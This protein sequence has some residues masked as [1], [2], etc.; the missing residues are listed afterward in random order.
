MSEIF[1][2]VNFLDRAGAVVV[3]LAL[4]LA[5]ITDKLVWHTRLKNAEARADR[6][7]AV[8][9][10]ALTTGAQAGVKAAETTAEL[11]SALPSDGKKG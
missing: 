6:W 9:L 3:V 10:K 5:V 8:A 11:V 2:D 7:E 4:A 1:M